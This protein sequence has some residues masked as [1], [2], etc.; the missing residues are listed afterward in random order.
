MVFTN[1]LETYI[2]EEMDLHVYKTSY[3]RNNLNSFIDC[4]STQFIETYY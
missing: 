1:D 4:N 2:S 3:L